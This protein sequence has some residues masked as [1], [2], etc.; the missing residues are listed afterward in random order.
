MDGWFTPSVRNVRTNQKEK[1]MAHIVSSSDG[2]IRPK[3]CSKADMDIL[4]ARKD[5]SDVERMVSVAKKHLPTSLSGVD[6]AY[7]K[8][9][10]EILANLEQTLARKGRM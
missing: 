6:E 9:C 3:L 7:K 8:R 1:Q 2:V 4:H 10:A 5:I